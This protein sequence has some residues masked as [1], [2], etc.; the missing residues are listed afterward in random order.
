MVEIYMKIS[1]FRL[2]WSGIS[3]D[4]AAGH[5]PGYFMEIFRR[6]FSLCPENMRKNEFIIIYFLINYKLY[7]LFIGSYLYSLF[8]YYVNG[9]YSA[10][11]EAP[12]P[13]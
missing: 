2:F 3:M 5:V 11:R 7:Y 13:G 1:W 10:N 4:R 8:F 9:N 12:L 6:H